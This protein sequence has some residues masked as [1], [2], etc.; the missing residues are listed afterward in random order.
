MYKTGERARELTR[1]VQPAQRREPKPVQVSAWSVALVLN[2]LGEHAKAGVKPSDVARAYHGAALQVPGFAGD[3]SAQWNLAQ[4]LEA[5]VHLLR[6]DLQAA[7][8]EL[9]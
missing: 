1:G 6:A 7:G 8:W 9:P 3:R 2:A 5:W 4:S